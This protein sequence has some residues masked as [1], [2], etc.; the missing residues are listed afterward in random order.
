MVLKSAFVAINH[1]VIAIRFSTEIACLISVS[2]FSIS[3]C[4][5]L[6][7]YRN[8]LFD[9]WKFVYQSLAVNVWLTILS[10]H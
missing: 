7:K 3:D 5:S 4:S 9:M 10:H 6:H 8:V 1:R 2:F